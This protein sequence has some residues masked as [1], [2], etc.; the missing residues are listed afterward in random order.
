VSDKQA[1]L[2]VSSLNNPLTL[3]LPDT[4]YQNRKSERFGSKQ[5][6]QTG[7]MQLYISIRTNLDAQLLHIQI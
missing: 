5:S 1:S 2:S 4:F 6:I 7:L 3:H